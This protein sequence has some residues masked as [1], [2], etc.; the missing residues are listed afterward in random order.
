[1]EQAISSTPFPGSDADVAR[2]QAVER[3][4]L[5]DTPPHRVFARIAGLAARYFA[6]PMASVSIVGRDRS[7]NLA[8]HGLPARQPVPRD[9]DLGAAAVISGVPFVVPDALRDPATAGNPLVREHQIAFYA[10]APIVTS[11]GHRLGT[12]A[13]MDTSARKPTGEQLSVL[14]DLAATVMEQLEFHRATLDAVGVERTLREAAEYARDEAR[15]DRDTAQLARDA[16]RRD[17]GEA[18]REL[19]H[20]RRSRDAARRDLDDAQRDRDGARLDRSDAQHARDA[21]QRDRDDARQDRDIA[22]RDRNIAE[23]DRDLTEE[24]AAVLQQTLLPPALPT[25]EGLSLASHYHPASSRRVGGDFYD[26]FALGDNRWAFF[27]GDVEGHGVG[28]AVATSLIRY[29]LRSAALHYRD[30]TEGLEELNSVLLRQFDPRR[31]CTVLFGTMEPHTDN[32]GFRITMATGGH[33]PA[34]LLDPASGKAY[35]VR[36]SEGMLVGMLR[37]VIFDACDF[38]LRRGQTLL[39]YTDGIVEARRGADPF[40]QDSLAGFAAERARLGASGLIGE[41]ATL[42][43]KLAPEDDVALLAFTVD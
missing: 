32:Q 31:F 40:D 15:M 29:T 11:D 34:L 7:W 30:P 8:A 4:R 37:N 13:V 17:R 24:Y 16:A 36:S 38:N 43:P 9:Q 20:A 22:I 21:A 12:V 2:V 25:I 6:T 27:I 10:C 35:A 26:V 18:L 23:Y 3:Y 28:A 1:M 14:T 41:I 42:V 19:D 33:P 39:L 5:F